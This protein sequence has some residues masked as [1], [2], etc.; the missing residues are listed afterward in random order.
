MNNKVRIDLDGN[1]LKCPCGKDNGSDYLHHS[2]VTSY[3]RH[4]DD[5]KRGVAAKCGIQDE[6]GVDSK[7]YCMV[8]ASMEGNPSSRRDGISIDFWCEHCNRKPVLNIIQHK[9]CTIIEWDKDTL[10]EK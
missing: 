10:E 2:S 8:T 9:G 7:P 6:D 4:G 1:I 3:F 5:S